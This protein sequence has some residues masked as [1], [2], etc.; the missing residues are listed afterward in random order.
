MPASLRAVVA[1]EFPRDV[2]RATALAGEMLRRHEYDR[3]FSLRLFATSRDA[4]ASHEL[5]CLASLALENQFRLATSDQAAS[6]L[7]GIGIAEDESVVRRRIARNDRIHSRLQPVGSHLRSFLRHTRRE[8]RLFFARY[9]FTPEEVVAV[10]RARTRATPARHDFPPL[11]HPY[12]VEE[13]KL[14]MES[15]PPYE[16]EIVRLL[17]DANV[18]YWV[19]DATPSSLNALV[20]Y[21]DGTIVLVI[22][23]PGSDIEIEIKRA[24]LRGPR[25]LDVRYRDG[26]GEVVPVHHHLWGGSRGDY[27]RFETANS[28][29]LARIHRLALGDEAPIPRIVTLARVESIPDAEGN[30]TSLLSH[31]SNL[32][33]RADLLGALEKL[34]RDDLVTPLDFPAGRFLEA[35]MP[36]QAIVVGTTSFRLERLR[37]YLNDGVPFDGDADELL[38]EIVD[39]YVPPLGQHTDHIAT[40][41]AHNRDAAD[42]TYLS[43]V[44]QIGRFWGAV[45]GMRGGSGGESFVI[46]NAGLRKVWAD[47][48]WQV[49]FIS[50]DHDS[51]ALAGRIHRFYNP[52]KNVNAFILDQAHILGGPTGKC[53][54][55]GELGALKTI[56][57]VSPAITSEGLALFR[58]T[59]RETY[60]R[61]LHA[62][63]TDPRIGKLFHPE[64]IKTL[65]EWDRIVIDFFHNARDADSKARWRKRTKAR[66]RRHGIPPVII[67]QYLKTIVT[68]TDVLPWFAGLYESATPSSAAAPRGSKNRGAGRGRASRSS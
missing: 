42:R 53:F 43:I 10:I 17:I 3:A 60:A 56:Y 34:D 32:A 55:P 40:A 62:M 12:N 49:R 13:A 59:L 45:L 29:L 52:A 14:A 51:M 22:K 18:V 44:T 54:H 57:R 19:D 41:L 67:E 1:E 24:G 26:N 5:R 64:Y 50:M 6:L 35:T 68:Y 9:A 66:L 25:P 38:D 23:P 28:A 15:L 4:N 48:R 2:T 37:M 61:T 46:R 63:S 36:T 21:P 16:R 27:L 7:R 11:I 65:R 31:F 20:E 8:C 33:C 47:G 39:D 30:A 58:A